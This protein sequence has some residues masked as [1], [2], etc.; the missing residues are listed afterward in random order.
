MPKKP[1]KN[2][3]VPNTLKI[4]LDQY[5]PDK[6]ISRRRIC[7][8]TLKDE[9]ED[10]LSGRCKADGFGIILR[11][12][13]KYGIPVARD[14]QGIAYLRK[15]AG[16]RRR[17]LKELKRLENGKPK[18]T[19]SLPKKP[20]GKKKDAILDRY[21]NDPAWQ[22]M[23]IVDCHECGKHLLAESCEWMRMLNKFKHVLPE[24][25]FTR[26]KERPYCKG[27]GNE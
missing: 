10:L 13:Q 27:C 17:V 26:V 18:T 8:E 3:H 11:T 21:A 23:K 19:L 15:L 14:F 25:V 9:R 12:V 7:A 16:H 6:P 24:K 2:R 20:A 5:G 1:H 22:D 4:G